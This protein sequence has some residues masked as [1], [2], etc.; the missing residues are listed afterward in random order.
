MWMP[1]ELTNFTV[2]GRQWFGDGWNGL[3]TFCA[4]AG[5]A[6]IELLASGATPE[7]A[8]PVDLIRGIHLRSLGS[9]LP[10]VGVDVP[11]F[12]AGSNRYA[13][14]ETYARLVETR[15][16]ELRQLAVF[17]PDYVVWH[18]VYAP[19]PFLVSGRPR[20]SAG[21]FLE[22][23]AKLVRDVC[24][25]YRPPCRLLFENAFGVGVGPAAMDET[26][27]FLDELGDLPVGLVLDIGHHLNTRRDIESSQ[28]ACHELLR[29]AESWCRHGLAAEV[30][31]L[32]WTPPHE[33]APQLTE[34]AVRDFASQAESTQREAVASSFFARSDRHLPLDGPRLAAAVGALSPAYVVHEMG[35]L[36]LD[37]HRLWLMRQ[38]KAIRG[39]DPQSGQE[40]S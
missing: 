25:E 7:T 34:E 3:R 15:A 31:H 30:L 33:V 37:D 39:S 4:E 29:L 16:D 13:A 32:H 11:D 40:A 12:G 27:T 8:P 36:S 19:F 21:H 26:A 5:L 2:W 35:A 28:D 17:D 20:I 1:V 23:L 14:C 10:L 6:G 9:W 22:H 24:S 18:G 38:A